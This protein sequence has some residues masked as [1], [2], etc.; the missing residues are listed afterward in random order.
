MSFRFPVI[1]VSLLSHPRLSGEPA[2]LGLQK[3]VQPPSLG[4][5]V[6]A[7]PSS[8]TLRFSACFP[9]VCSQHGSQSA[10]REIYPPGA[11][12]P[13]LGTVQAA[14]RLPRGQSPRPKASDL[15]RPCVAPTPCL[16][17]LTSQP[18]HRRLV[19]THPDLAT[20]GSLLSLKTL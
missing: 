13:L 18:P 5:C 6:A 2:G 14:A 1:L 9:L 4:P 10:P 15:L 11:S 7:E 16:T 3:P 17:P 20:L 12:T 19:L 8:W